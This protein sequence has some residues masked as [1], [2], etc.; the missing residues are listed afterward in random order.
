MSTNIW[1][2]LENLQ[3]LSLCDRERIL[4]RGC[5][6]LIYA[7]FTA[8]DEKGLDTLLNNLLA[9]K[10]FAETKLFDTERAVK[11]DAINA[12]LASI[13][14]D[15]EC[16]GINKDIAERLSMLSESVQNYVME[17]ESEEECDQAEEDAYYNIKALMEQEIEKFEANSDNSVSIAEVLP[18]MKELPDF[19]DTL[20]AVNA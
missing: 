2:F 17:D 3:A 1:S 16:N 6:E 18:D 13:N 7:L 4:V 8:R 19:S 11:L 10:D 20:E 5:I 9:L 15:I 14:K 12:S